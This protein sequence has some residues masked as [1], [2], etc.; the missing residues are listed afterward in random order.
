MNEM[1]GQSLA[2]LMGVPRSGTT[3]LSHLL[4]SHPQIASPPEPWL[5]FAVQA[6]GAV[7]PLHPAGSQ[8][9]GE[10]YAQ[11]VE[12]LDVGRA[13]AACATALYSEYLCREGKSI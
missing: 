6:M 2:F 10:A 1:D 4:D 13:Q 5:M 12:G 9:I 7:H 8:L 3:L 11:F